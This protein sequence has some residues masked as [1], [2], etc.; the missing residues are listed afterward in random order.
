M[1]ARAFVESEMPLP[2]SEAKAAETLARVARRL[3]DAAG[4]AAAALRSAVRQARFSRDTK[5][6]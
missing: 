3:V 1:K 2:G 6:R 5:C 4:I